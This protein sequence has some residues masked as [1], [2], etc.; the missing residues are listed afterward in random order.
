MTLP[1]TPSSSL[2]LEKN[3]VGPA[4]GEAGAGPSRGPS[5]GA[6]LSSIFGTSPCAIGDEFGVPRARLYFKPVLF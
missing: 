1:S 5:C 6:L 2:S 4:P 3:V